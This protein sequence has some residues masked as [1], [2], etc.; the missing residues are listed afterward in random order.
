[1]KKIV[2]SLL[3][4]FTIALNAVVMAGCFNP[5]PV[6]DLTGAY[7]GSA[8]TIT[9]AH[10][11]GQ[12]NKAVLEDAIA[13]FNEI[14][15][16]ITVEHSSLG[17]YDTVFKTVQTQLT[18]S[19]EKYP[20]FAFCYPDHVAT[21]NRS[22]STVCLD[23]LI[24]STAVVA[25]TNETMGFTQAQLDDF[26]EIYYNEGKSYGD[27][28]MYS[29]PFQKST[30]VLY[31]NKKVFDKLGLE[32]PKTWD[33]V[34][35]CAL[36]L[37]EAYP[38]ST[39]IGYDSE[40]N[41]FIT[42]S[43]QYGTDYTD[44]SKNDPFTF[45]NDENK[46]LMNKFAEWYKS[47]LFTT[48]S[49]ASAGTGTSS[50]YTSDYFTL[51]DDETGKIFM[52]IGSSAGARYQRPDKVNGE[53]PFEVGVAPVPQASETN[54]KVISQGPSVCIFEKSNVQ[55]VYAS[56][57]LIKFLLTDTQFQTQYAMKSGYVPVIKSVLNS[58]IYKNHLAKADGGD[59]LTA[60]VAVVTF[61]Q[62]DYYFF[63]D[64]FDGSVVA[65]EQVGLL[66]NEIFSKYTIGADNS[67]MINN[68][69][70]NAYDRCQD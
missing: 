14:Y 5:P 27:G 29:L 35:A 21:Y 10:S 38:K 63:S 33:D 50:S 7:D 30:E 60:S 42:L 12:D 53:Y 15:P 52:S 56:W 32:A 24:N 9:F 16:N 44:A 67:A 3:L 55:E 69:F 62:E 13:R 23:D 22:E 68:A 4:L 39:P 48:S 8:V 64:V 28:K 49:L 40:E 66:V 57:L 18:G 70:E 61:E 41:F 25:G 36:A 47:G 34:Y 1:M 6:L 2:V 46:E 51:G 26:I 17:D 31:Y 19:G 58:Q 45:V 11:M 20:N 37:K 43:E 59:Y 54:K 65:R